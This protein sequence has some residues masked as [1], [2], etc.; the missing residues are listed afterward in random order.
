MNYNKLVFRISSWSDLI[1]KTLTVDFARGKL[2][3]QDTEGILS[4][5]ITPDESSEIRKKLSSSHM[6]EWV[7][8]YLPPADVAVFDG[9][10]W[11][12]KLF[13]GR[14]LVKKST[15]SNAVPSPQQWNKLNSAV[16]YGHYIA[17]EQGKKQPYTTRRKP[18]I[19]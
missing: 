7:E 16:N 6:E 19:G 12:L 8:V 9:C 15:G 2:E 18:H 13:D 3:W 17:L 5:S 4:C 1:G 10:R 14:K 11:S